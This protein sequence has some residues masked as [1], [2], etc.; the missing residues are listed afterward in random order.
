LGIPLDVYDVLEPPVRDGLSACAAGGRA[1]GLKVLEPLDVLFVLGPLLR[2]K[3][4]EVRAGLEKPPPPPVVEGLNTPPPRFGPI[5]VG[6]L[7]GFTELATRLKAVMHCRT[8]AGSLDS[9]RSTVRK[10]SCAGMFNG[11]ISQALRKCDMFS[12][13][14]KGIADFLN[15]TPGFGTARLMSLYNVS[16]LVASSVLHTNPIPAQNCPVFQ[17][18]QQVSSRQPVAQGTF[19]PAPYFIR[20][21]WSIPVHAQPLHVLVE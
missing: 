14:M 19:Y 3:P 12:I 4:G 7:E 2:P 15:L 11:G 16:S 18:I 10:R 17:R 6:K 5:L 9:Y 21:F 13:C 8:W 20:G 1:S